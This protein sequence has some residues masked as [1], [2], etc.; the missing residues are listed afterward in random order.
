MPGLSTGGSEV[1][2]SGNAGFIAYVLGVERHLQVTVDQDYPATSEAKNTFYTTFRAEV[3]IF[4]LIS[5]RLS[6]KLHMQI[7]YSGPSCSK[8]TRLS[9]SCVFVKFDSSFNY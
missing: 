7:C 2:L 4:S 1:F 9:K 3:G 5:M 6:L 8:P